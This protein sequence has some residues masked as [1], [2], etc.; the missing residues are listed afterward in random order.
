MDQAGT[1]ATALGTAFG[2]GGIGIVLATRGNLA[3]LR[4]SV[5]VRRYLTWLA[6]AIAYGV[7]VILGL[8]GVAVLATALAIQAARELAPLLGLVGPYRVALIGLCAVLPGLTLAGGGGWTA[9]LVLLVAG[10][11]PVLRGQPGEIGRAA[12]LAFGALLAGWTLAQL[13]PL[14]RAGQPWVVLV[15][16]GTAVS[17]ICAFTAGSLLGGPRL[18]PRISPGKTWSGLAGNLIGAALVLPLIAPMLPPLDGAA[19]AAIVL[20]IGLGGC[21]GDL[22]ESTIKRGAAVKDAGNWLPGF[23]GLLDRIDSLLI[24]VPLLALLVHVIG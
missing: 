8:P 14:A 5:L 21:L 3:R 23:G 22:I 24:V 16:F 11:L 18:A 20:T 12:N 7:P 17:D 1:L 19:L 10:L 6:L 15:L 4:D 13:I 9:G 2:V